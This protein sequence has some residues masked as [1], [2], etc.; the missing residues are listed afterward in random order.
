MTKRTLG[1]TNI[2]V[3]RLSGFL[4]RMQ[5]KKGRKIIKAR[6]TKGRKRLSLS[7]K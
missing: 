7:S 6:R 1:G 2:K 3:I 5:T 4:S